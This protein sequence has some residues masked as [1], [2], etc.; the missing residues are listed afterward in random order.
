MITAESAP[1]SVFTLGS[2]PRRAG[3]RTA[4]APTPMLRPPSPRVA[5]RARCQRVQGFARERARVSI[6]ASALRSRSATTSERR[7][8]GYWRLFV[9]SP[10]RSIFGIRST[11]TSKIFAASCTVIQSDMPSVFRDP[12]QTQTTPGVPPAAGA[13]PGVA[14]SR[15]TT[16][17]GG[18]RRDGTVPPP[19]GHHVHCNLG[20]SGRRRSLDLRADGELR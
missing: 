20:P 14:S 3:T 1:A 15:D 16:L 7:S 18:G 9:S 11:S 8:V 19:A 2:L 4:S 17:P 12:M 6:S 13:T 5:R 10:R